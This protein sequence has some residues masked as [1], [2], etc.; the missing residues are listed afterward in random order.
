MY[1]KLI[2]RLR[3]AYLQEALKLHSIDY[4]FK[5]SVSSLRVWKRSVASTCRMRNNFTAAK[6][7][8]RLS[9][10]GRVL[11]LLRSRCGQDEVAA[12]SCRRD[13]LWRCG[14]G[15][16]ESCG[17]RH[18]WETNTPC[19]LFY[20]QINRSH[21]AVADNHWESRRLEFYL[22]SIF[23]HSEKCGHSR[24]QVHT[25]IWFWKYWRE[26]SA[27]RRYSAAYSAAQHN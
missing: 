17:A 14:L 6:K 7:F 8:W 22:R 16:A 21:R 5:R 26:A 12:A 25:A 13:A 2:F 1:L 10:L 18:D 15:T 24:S 27:L 9:R 3:K 23:D 19:V 20:S 4:N 11:A